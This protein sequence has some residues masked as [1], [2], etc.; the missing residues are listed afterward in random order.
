MT[1]A[2]IIGQLQGG[3]IG[4]TRYTTVLAGSKASL[5][6]PDAVNIQAY[7]DPGT[8]ATPAATEAKLAG[9]L[10]SFRRNDDLSAIEGGNIEFQKRAAADTVDLIVKLMNAGTRSDKFIIK[11]EGGIGVPNTAANV[12]TPSGATAR[13]MEIFD[14]T[15]ASLGFIPIYAARW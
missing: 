1:S 12:N 9:L 8:T 14:E 4:G 15:G 5:S 3:T 13:D 7:Y 6:T 2:Q 11:A 10:A